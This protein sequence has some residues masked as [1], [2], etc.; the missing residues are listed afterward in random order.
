MGGGGGGS[1]P[2]QHFLDLLDNCYPY[3]FS[4]VLVQLYYDQIFSGQIHK[5]FD[6]LL[7]L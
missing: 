1:G 2:L 4:S 6:E 3:P 7:C 5:I